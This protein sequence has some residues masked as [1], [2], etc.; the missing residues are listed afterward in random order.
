MSAV[1]EELLGRIDKLDEEQQRQV[2]EYIRILEKPQLLTWD[3][4]L[5]LADQAQA[6]LR[7]KYGEKHYFNSQSILDEVREERLNDILGSH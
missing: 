4:W 2:L 7:S 6:E 3:Q 5:E 1:K